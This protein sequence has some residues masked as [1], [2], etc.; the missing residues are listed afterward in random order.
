MA[1]PR[2]LRILLNLPEPKGSTPKGKGGATAAPANPYLAAR[3]VPT[4]PW[5][6][7]ERKRNPFLTAVRGL[8][9]VVLVLLVIT[10]LRVWFKPQHQNTTP[11]IPA[12]LNYPREAASG[13]ALRF[14]S[15]YLTWDGSKGNQQQR[16]Q[17]L[18]DAGWGGDPKIGWNGQGRAVAG[19]LTVASVEAT[20]DKTGAV[21]V[22]GPWTVYD[23]KGKG[24]TRRIGLR[25]PVAVVKDRPAVTGAPAFVA[26]PS[27][28]DP[29]SKTIETSVMDSQL[30]SQTLADAKTFFQAY[31]SSTDL[32]AITAPGSTLQGLGGTV[33]LAEV[34]KWR[35]AAPEAATPSE[36]SAYASVA[37]QTANGS[38][39][40]QDYT[41]RLIKATAGNVS[42]WQVTS[43]TS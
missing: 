13:A 3:P 6:M 43:I 1:V 27:P 33:K 36:T 42:R 34:S 18:A 17:A 20:D 4:T 38:V 29:P 24:T 39:V 41:V 37:W 28:V 14:G 21:T 8:L 22:T 19:V 11:Q 25:I 30:T 16:A 2:W 31:G 23:A 5:Q 35:V 10:G 9:L 7:E 26:A 40:Q 12:A 15:A 32:S